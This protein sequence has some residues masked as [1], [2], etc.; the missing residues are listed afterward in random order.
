LHRPV[1]ATDPF[2]LLPFPPAIVVEVQRPARAL[3]LATLLLI[4]AA[5]HAADPAQPELLVFGASSL[6]NALADTGAAY[7]R[8]TGQEVRFSFAA[9]AVGAR[10]IEAGARA[11][12]FFSADIEWMDYLEARRLVDPGTR[13][14]VVSNR[15]A[16]IAPVDSAVVLKIAPGFPL[17]A[18]LGSGRLAT[19]DP[20]YV[21]AGRYGRSAL[22]ALG[23]WND[24]ANRIVRADNVRSALMF[25]ARGEAPL[26][27]VYQTDALAEGKVRIVDLFPVSSHP[28]ISYPAAAT[29]AARPGAA[30][31]VEF[32]LTPAAHDI[33]ARY[34]FLDP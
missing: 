15:L 22:T 13:H 5:S 21:P 26:G 23:V 12:V 17:A 16:L 34:G 3:L 30:R 6:T 28:K 25:V 9:S 20:D 33:F 1:E 27:I 32:L 10:Q 19:G 31:F 18:A 24:V 14:D 29:P 11:D 7:T 8:A 2:L 4:G